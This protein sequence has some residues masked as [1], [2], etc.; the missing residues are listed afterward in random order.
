MPAAQ[1]AIRWVGH[2]VTVV[3]GLVLVVNDHLLKSVWPGIATGK[4]SDVAGLVVAPPL[5]ALAVGLAF[6]RLAVRWLAGF[7]ITAIGLGFALVKLT[8]IGADV[9]SDAWTLVAGPSRVLR[10]PTDLVALPALGLAWW[11]WVRGARRVP[12]SDPV[13]AR[14]R[15]MVAFP[16]LLLTV[17]ATSA[18]DVDAVT[19]VGEQDGAVVI[20][21][22]SGGAWSSVTGVGDWR[23]V[24]SIRQTSD[25]QDCVPGEPSHCYRVYGADIGTGTIEQ[26]PNRGRLLGVDE[27]LDGGTTW[28][29]AWEVPPDRWQFLADQHAFSPEDRR[30]PDDPRLLASVD[31]L[32]RLVPTGHQVIVANGIDGLAV[33]D[34]DGAWHRVGVSGNTP[35]AYRNVSIHPRPLTALGYG[36]GEE[37]AGAIV[38][39]A[40]ALVLASVLVS[41]R[42]RRVRPIGAVVWPTVA[43]GGYVASVMGFGMLVVFPTT[44]LSMLAAGLAVVGLMTVV[45]TQRELPYSRALALAG[46]V[47]LVGGG[48]AAP[49][50]GWTVAWPSS[51]RTATILAWSFALVGTGVALVVA[52]W[53]GGRLNPPPW[54]P[55]PGLPSQTSSGA[56]SKSTNE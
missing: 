32:V 29:T 42:I 16:F 56:P 4:L 53:A 43:V 51:Y 52:W 19:T 23:P 54:R 25:K 48:F 55:V 20:V 21:T 37:I 26:P 30:L 44:A 39:A 24:S 33:R 38:V 18:T 9:A 13:V 10:D 5:L 3:A 15:A 40:G 41:W 31:I 22:R 6:P 1:Y 8:W 14:V 35:D 27:T 11:S 28:R 12:V 49:Y 45:L 47:L 50:L 46:S 36:L 2:P 17:T 7:A 34:P